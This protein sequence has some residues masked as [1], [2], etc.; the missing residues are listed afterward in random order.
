MQA[1]FPQLVVM[2]GREAGSCGEG[3]DGH[4]V[5]TCGMISPVFLLSSSVQRSS[6]LQAGRS[7]DSLALPTQT[8]PPTLHQGVRECCCYN[9]TACVAEQSSST[10][11]FQSFLLFIQ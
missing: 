8:V 1:G 4:W 6:G 2:R 7:L 11:R 10:E 3:R 5:R 9:I